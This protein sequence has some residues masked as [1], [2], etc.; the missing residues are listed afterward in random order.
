MI[1]SIYNNA[2]SL[3]S[4]LKWQE[5]LSQ[6]L[7]SSQVAGFKRQ[8]FSVEGQD[9]ASQGTEEKGAA[10]RTMGMP[11][12]VTS[13]DLQPGAIR[14]TDKPT[15]FAIGGP[16][17]FQMQGP[18]GNYY[19]RNGEFHL[20]HENTLVNNLGHPVLG[21][22]GPIQVDPEEGPLSVSRDG[23][24]SQGELVLGNLSLFQF[25]NENEDLRAISGGFLPKDGVNPTPVET[26]SIVQGAIENSNVSP[27]NEMINLIMVS[28]AYAASQK[29]ITTQDT[30]LGQAIQSLG[31]PPMGA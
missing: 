17:Y 6:N 21:S 23:T 26:P 30:L 8:V 16:G 2:A 27:M 14:S 29:V 1:E 3:T 5:T 24:I 19:T 9:G 15:D 20:N 7:S 18:N 28:N 4:L 12:G 13:T 25:P 11:K 31:A 10:N 22:G